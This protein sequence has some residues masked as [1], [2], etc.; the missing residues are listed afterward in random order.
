MLLFVVEAAFA[1][2]GHGV[3][4]TPGIGKNDV[5]VGTPIRLLRPDGT[6]LHSKICGIALFNESHDILVGK[7]I[8]KE[9]VPVGTEVWV[10][11]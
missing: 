11:E 6:I 7:E 1:I 5:R 10:D 9:D 3:I 8:R 4:L 2:T